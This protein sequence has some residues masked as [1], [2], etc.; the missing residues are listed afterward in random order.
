ML[1]VR[2]STSSSRIRTP[3]ALDDSEV[4]R[5]GGFASDFLPRSRFL[6]AASSLPLRE[7]LREM[8]RLH[9]SSRFGARSG[10]EEGS[11]WRANDADSSQLVKAR[12]M[13]GHFDK[14]KKEL[15]RAK[16]QMHT[17]PAKRRYRPK[18]YTC[19]KHALL[20]ADACGCSRMHF[21]SPLTA[22]IRPSSSKFT[23]FTTNHIFCYSD[24]NI[25][26]TIVNLKLVS[27][28]FWYNM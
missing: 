10:S 6:A 13:N 12:P 20:R 26:L 28:H 19:R 5:C 14:T 22:F 18:V 3:A 4:S 11:G 27:N 21:H 15:N 8:K 17:R 16:V 24:R 7:R 2:E 9:S 25:G 1:A 23:K